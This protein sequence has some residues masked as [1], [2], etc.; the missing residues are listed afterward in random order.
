MHKALAERYGVRL[1]L[2]FGSAA[3]GKTHARSDVD[4]AVLLDRPALSLED[5]A[6]LSH[7]LQELFPGRHID[8]ALVNHAD[9]LFLK[10]ITEHCRI[11]FGTERQLH[12]LKM[13][14]FKRYQD[15]RRFLSMERSF[16]ERYS[17]PSGGRHDR[18]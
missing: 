10:K 5:Y 16:V 17:L 9:P 7:A 8:L 12:L 6:G 14:A 13:Y 4:I 15:H 2:L 1:A 3:T 11:L 18:R